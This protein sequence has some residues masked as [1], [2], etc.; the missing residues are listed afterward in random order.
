MEGP[1]TALDQESPLLTADDGADSEPE[2]IAALRAAVWQ[3][4]LDL[5]DA[6]GEIAELRQS[7]A[8]LTSM[9]AELA[10]A[11]N[12][13]DAAGAAAATPAFISE[14]GDIE[15]SIA[16][17]Q[18]DVDA[19]TALRLDAEER[20]AGREAEIARLEDQLASAQAET[21]WMA[22]GKA[23]VEASLQAQAGAWED[24]RR[25]LVALGAGL[26]PEGFEPVAELA[27]PPVEQEQAAPLAPEAAG[28]DAVFAEIALLAAGIDAMRLALKDKEEALAAASAPPSEVAA[29]AVNVDELQA[30]AS[31][32]EATIAG[33]QSELAQT[34]TALAQAQAETNKLKEENARAEESKAGEIAAL[35]AAAA[36]TAKTMREKDAELEEAKSTITDLEDQTAKLTAEVQRL[37]AEQEQ[38]RKGAA[39]GAAVVAAG[40]AKAIGAEE[41]A[42]GPAA[43][44][45][46]PQQDAGEVEL[47]RLRAELE[48]LQRTLDSVTA[49]RD[50]ALAQAPAPAETAPEAAE[51]TPSRVAAKTAP[52]QAA[53]IFGV[54]PQTTAI[55]QD[56]AALRGIGP[57]YEQRMYDRGIG[58]YWEIANLT[59]EEFI[60]ILK[61]SK[62]AQKHLDCAAVRADALRLARETYSMGFIWDGEAVDDLQRIEGIG[63]V[64]EQ[65][66]YDAGVRTFD[67]LASITLEQLETIIGDSEP[68]APDF[69][70]WVNQARVLAAQRT[71]S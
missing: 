38:D 10:A 71:H 24:A 29:A 30:Q 7:V 26:Q 59:D 46:P 65:R 13:R 12:A 2:G 69:I 66:L 36:A 17:L 39:V 20:L 61:P 54:H 67:Q 4:E 16:A 42:P 1:N 27:A 6:R 32:A 21:E 25:R 33:L 64:M 35:T 51:A 58:T 19:A 55:V 37:K 60:E 70:D 40:A 62:A 63:Q 18:N 50:A 34:Q 52:L 48:A 47:A 41:A 44:T 22:A 56:L 28:P 49:E 43:A 57:V 31:Q 68:F 3:R 53:L 11:L 5:V 8:I 45:E 14:V 23:D 9:G 15:A